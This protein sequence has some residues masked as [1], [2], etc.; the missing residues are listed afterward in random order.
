M[1]ADGE[2]PTCS[3]VPRWRHCDSFLEGAG[4]GQVSSKTKGGREEVSLRCP[5]YIKGRPA[6]VNREQVSLCLP[7][8]LTVL[9]RRSGG[10]LLLLLL[11]Q[12]TVHQFSTFNN[13]NQG[14]LTS[15]AGLADAVS[16]RMSPFLPSQMIPS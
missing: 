5:L 11:I 13:L 9:L 15:G 3:M 16:G 8:Y 2:T 4:R 1:D 14:P 12:D 10:L 6:R 7:T